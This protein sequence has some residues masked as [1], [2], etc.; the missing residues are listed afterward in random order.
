M[1]PL[2]GVRGLADDYIT[3]TFNHS[4]SRAEKKALERNNLDNTKNSS[5]D[6]WK[7]VRGCLGWGDGGPPTQLFIDGRVVTSPG[8]LASVMNKFFFL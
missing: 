6:I 5:T 2:I 8:G 7:S 1:F 4:Q 3:S